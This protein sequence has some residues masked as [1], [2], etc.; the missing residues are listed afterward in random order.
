MRYFTLILSWLCLTI[1][2]VTGCDRNDTSSN[3]SDEKPLEE[4][5]IAGI[6][7]GYLAQFGGHTGK[8]MMGVITEE[9]M[10]MLVTNDAQYIGPA[11]A[12]EVYP[13]TIVVSGALSE[14]LYDDD[15]SDYFNVTSSANSY[16][17]FILSSA[18]TL[19]Q[20][21]QSDGDTLQLYYNTTYDKVPPNVA[22]LK[23]VWHLEDTSG[24]GESVSL[25]I[26][27]DTANTTASG[28]IRV[29]RGMTG[30]NTATGTD[31]FESDS[32]TIVIHYSN[33]ARNAYDVS[34]TTLD[35]IELAGLA[36]YVEGVS[37][38]GVNVPKMMA[39]GVS[40]ASSGNIKSFSGL[41]SYYTTLAP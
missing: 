24:I 21:G 41:A 34:L 22:S 17:G 18:L 4:Q 12:L 31:M 27:P 3:D 28:A 15:P 16:D 38:Q 8:F 23:G 1:L 40:G 35:S 11:G 6:W 25:I 20:S 14:Y 37:T 32:G 36:A 30:N 5:E 13:D 10:V 26:T 19:Y 33:P 2:F 29:K 7:W 9:H 39:I